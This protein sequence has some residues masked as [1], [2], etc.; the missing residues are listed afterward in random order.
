MTY[1]GENGTE[2]YDNVVSTF[3]SI[4]EVNPISGVD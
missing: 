2:T 4:N 1:M 3:G